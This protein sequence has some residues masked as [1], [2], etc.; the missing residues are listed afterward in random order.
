MEETG[1]L[2]FILSVQFRIYKG[3]LRDQKKKTK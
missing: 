3:A 2:L 1:K